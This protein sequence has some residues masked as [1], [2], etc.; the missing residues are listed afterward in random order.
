MGG[1][2]AGFVMRQSTLQERRGEVVGIARCLGETWD[3]VYV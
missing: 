1:G 3:E 2:L